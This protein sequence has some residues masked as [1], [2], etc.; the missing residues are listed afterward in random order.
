M[1]K[2]P[3]PGIYGSNNSGPLILLYSSRDRV[4][5]ILSVGL[6][7]CNYQVVQAT[8]VSLAIVKATQ[9]LPDIVVIDLSCDNPSDILLASRL[10]KS[11]RTR[12]MAVLLIFSKNPHPFILQEMAE[13]VDKSIGTAEK[14]LLYL[15]YPFAFSDFLKKILA[16]SPRKPDSSVSK[17]IT[18]PDTNRGV[19]EKLFDLSFPA[20]KKLREIESLLQKQWAFPFTVVRAFD[21]LESDRSCSSQLAKC[22]SADP[23]VSSAVLRV[24]NTV[25]YARRQGR[26]S[27]IND[28]VVRLGFRETRNI[29][30]CLTLIQLTPNVNDNKG[31]ERQEFW[32]HSLAVALI[33]EKLCIHCK[34][35]KPEYAFMAGLLHDLGKIPLDN[36]FEQVFARLLDETI[37]GLGAFY[38][39]E[40]RMMGFTHAELGHYLTTTWNFPSSISLAITNHH[41][42]Q[43]I[44][45]APSVMD[46]IIQAAVFVANLLAKALSIGHSCDEIIQEVPGEMVRDLKLNTGPTDR[47]IQEIIDETRIFCQFMNLGMQR[48]NAN[49][50]N[51]REDEFRIL[52]VNENSSVYHPLTTALSRNGFLVKQTAN[53]K[54][55]DSSARVIISIPKKGL[56]PD[57]VLYDDDRG[58]QGRD[59]TLKIFLVS[60]DLGKNWSEDLQGS[61]IKFMDRD[62]LDI[63]V[64][65]QVLDEFFGKISTPPQEE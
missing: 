30:A 51:P 34:F 7:Q 20:S 54:H 65:V 44:L 31:F 55:V 3:T 37:A 53:I 5:D 47:F 45:Q 22:I 38:L 1:N 4:R 32:L 12:K 35:R 18:V 24:V 25:F 63:R 61:D 33:A 64:L 27:D 48:M 26:I 29:V 60:I 57:I 46:R 49:T 36:N 23:A 42:T 13:L 58:A 59:K 6:I 15:G 56:P 14:M 41:S 8:T 40:E 16:L 19:E 21:I 17:K 11:V 28:A 50:L 43:M 9:M 10:R 52:V 62:N 2:R 39:T